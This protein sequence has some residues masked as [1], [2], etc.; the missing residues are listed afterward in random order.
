MDGCS[1]ADS[2]AASTTGLTKQEPLFTRMDCAR[3]LPYSAITFCIRQSLTGN[4]WHAEKGH[5]DNLNRGL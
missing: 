4:R 2:I 1:S 3:F 5:K